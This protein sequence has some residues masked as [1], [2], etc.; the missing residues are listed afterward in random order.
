MSL[1][2]GGGSVGGVGEEVCVGEVCGVCVKTAPINHRNFLLNEES[3]DC[4]TKR[5]VKEQRT[6]PSAPG[7]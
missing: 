2:A 4:I 7:G 6:T 1:S 5:D 3:I